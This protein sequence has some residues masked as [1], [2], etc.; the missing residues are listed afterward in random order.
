[1]HAKVYLKTVRETQEILSCSRTTLHRLSQAG[2]LTP[3]KLGRSVR[4][5][6]DQIEQV[7]QHGAAT[8][9]TPKA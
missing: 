2:R 7:A 6:L 8:G 1:M 3:V 4:F 5:R 9:T